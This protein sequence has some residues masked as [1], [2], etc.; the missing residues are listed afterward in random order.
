VGPEAYILVTLASSVPNTLDQQTGESY[1]FLDDSF[2][3]PTLT[4]EDD[5]IMDPNAFPNAEVIE[6]IDWV[7]SSISFL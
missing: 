4:Q 2:L 6:N 3:D 1:D 5:V 7:C